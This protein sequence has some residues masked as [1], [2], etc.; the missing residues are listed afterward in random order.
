MEYGV[1]NTNHEKSKRNYDETQK[2]SGSQTA[3]ERHII[4][5]R[6]ISVTMS[7]ECGGRA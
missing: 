1:H 4:H 5:A 3:I 2:R 6:E 7:I